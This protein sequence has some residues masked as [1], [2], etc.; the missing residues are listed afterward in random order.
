VT[1]RRLRYEPLG[2]EEARRVHEAALARLA[3]RGARLPSERAL[4]V[5]EAAG[6][7]VDRAAGV[8]RLPAALVSGA[9]DRAPAA[10]TLA[11]RTPD[12]DVR[13]GDGSVALAAA[14]AAAWVV[15]L[16]SGVR[17]AADACDV[18]DACR[19]ADALDEVAAVWAPPPRGGEAAGVCSCPSAIGPCATGTVKHIVLADVE[20]VAAAAATAAAAALAGSPAAARERPPL[21]ALQR[22]PDD[23]ARTAALVDAALTLADAGL[24]CGF[25]AAPDA[26]SAHGTLG[27]LANA[28][29][30]C[31]A[32]VLAACALQQLAAPGAPFVVPA[33][34][35][36]IAAQAPNCGAGPPL[37]ATTLGLA[38]LAGLVH[39]PVAVGIGARESAPAGW[40]A[41]VDGVFAATAGA[42]S[43]ASLVVG[44]GLLDADTYSSTRALMDAETFSY[45]AFCA[46][47]IPVDDETIALE[48]IAAVGVGGNALGQKHT[49]RHMKDVWRPRLFDRAPYEVW[50]RQ[51][52]LTA[53]ERAAALARQLL[54]EHETP[55]LEAETAATLQR[56]IARSGL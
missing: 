46:A 9:V 49:R 28:L 15:D 34:P 55:E 22:A 21:S 51:G 11:G 26:A 48:T 2:G 38:Q 3:Q 10:V 37:Y 4:D 54:A 29:V 14:A 23:G 18:S 20:G 42:L 56:I 16:E 40:E 12:H 5:L 27:S 39:L 52:R 45:A 13:L 53:D 31:H 1:V 8:A 24:P 33:L 25:T 44:A 35:E 19:L 7:D 50:E 32:A 41:A 47:G 17:R 43:R 36:V 30:V 6:A